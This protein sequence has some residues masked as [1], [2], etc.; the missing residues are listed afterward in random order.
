MDDDTRIADPV[1]A[2]EVN[3]SLGMGEQSPTLNEESPKD[4]LP[5]AAKER[6]GRQEKRHKKEMR[7]M[8][9]QIMD[10]QNRVVPPPPLQAPSF[11]QQ[12]PMNPYTQ[13][14][15]Q[16]GGAD[17]QIHRA[18]SMALQAREQQERQAQHA[19]QAMEVQQE[20]QRFNQRL[21][22]ASDKYDDFDDSVRSDDAKF[23]P[24]MRDA[25]MVMPNAEDVLYKLGKNRSE[26]E[27]ISKLNPIAQ[28]RELLSLGY[29][30][31]GGD[32]GKGNNAPQPKVMGQ[33]KG[34]PMSSNGIDGKTPVSVLRQKLRSG[35]R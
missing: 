2:Q 3:D 9:A 27:R 13:Q 8:Q 1:N 4:D 7:A 19:H 12:Q 5:L 23:T 17:E 35:W 24:A 21:D 18:V 28:Q 11:Q 30:L 32:M 10:L 22:S 20:L 26:L 6:L 14:P 16:P 34:T 29:A 25:A 33:I 15:V 31:H